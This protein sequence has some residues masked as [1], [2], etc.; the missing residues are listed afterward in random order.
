VADRIAV[1]RQALA[2]LRSAGMETGIY[3]GRFWWIVNMGDTAEFVGERLWLAD[4]GMN[5]PAAP[6]P[7]IRETAFGGFTKVYRHQYSST[8]VA[9]GRNRD[10]NYEIHEEVDAMTPEE[11]VRMERLERI[12]AANGI[13]V[14]VVNENLALLREIGGTVELGQVVRLTDEAAL[15]YLDRI[16]ASLTGSLS[17]LNGVVSGHTNDATAHAIHGTVPEHRHKPGAVER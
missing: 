9:C 5:N 12:V 1:L 15:K 7:P 17:N 14:H 16:G 8:I 4:Y 2:G 3:T 6:R 11:K 10:H 13:E